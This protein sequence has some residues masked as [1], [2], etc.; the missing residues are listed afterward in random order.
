VLP[1]QPE[2]GCRRKVID[3]SPVLDI[4]P[5]PRTDALIPVIDYGIEPLRW[6]GCSECGL[7]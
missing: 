5:V 6:R 4:S 7:A 1:R 2:D 3:I